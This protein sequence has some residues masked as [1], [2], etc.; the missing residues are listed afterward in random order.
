V[1]RW[2]PEKNKRHREEDDGFFGETNFAYHWRKKDKASRKLAL[3][4]KRMMK[5]GFAYVD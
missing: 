5:V 1:Q 2:R 3:H 4:Y